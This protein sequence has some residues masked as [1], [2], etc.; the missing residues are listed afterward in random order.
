MSIRIASV[1]L[2]LLAHGTIFFYLGGFTPHDRADAAA[3]ESLRVALVRAENREPAAP[4]PT[5]AGPE[6]APAGPAPAAFEPLPQ[7][8]PE[9]VVSRATPPPDVSRVEPE[10]VKIPQAVL[11]SRSPDRAVRPVARPP[12]PVSKARK[13][14][15]VSRTQPPATEPVLPQPPPAVE[16]PAPRLASTAPVNGR[17]PHETSKSPSPSAEAL[18][19]IERAYM[20]ALVAAIERHKRYPLRARKRGYEG[21]VL[22]RFTV[23]RD[24]T[25]SRIEIGS[26]SF[27]TILDQAASRAVRDLGR[28]APIPP[29]LGRDRWEFRVPIRFAMN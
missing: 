21:E 19:E 2:S 4:E 22:V 11:A 27:Q 26:S 18:R 23:L 29:Q 5:P 17:E 6:P 13:E 16:P 8:Q 28:F 1:F 15:P 7:P 3:G 9:E 20:D 10:P 25:I 12:E 14:P 24:G